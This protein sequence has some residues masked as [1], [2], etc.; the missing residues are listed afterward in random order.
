[1]LAITVMA[2]EGPEVDD[3]LYTALAK[4]VDRVVKITGDWSACQSMG[5][6]RF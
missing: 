6:G 1:M 2:L 3:A 5:Q 4:G